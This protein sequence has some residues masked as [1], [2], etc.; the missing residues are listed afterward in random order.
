VD[1]QIKVFQSA[2]WN[3]Y[4][5]FKEAPVLNSVGCNLLENYIRYRITVL[6]CCKLLQLY[7]VIFK[8]L[9]LNTSK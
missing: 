2:W 1:V 8:K 3:F 4:M 7:I 9:F 5:D 6:T